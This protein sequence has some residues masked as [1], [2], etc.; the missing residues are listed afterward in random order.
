MKQDGK[1]FSPIS[2]GNPESLLQQAADGELV[3]FAA[4]RQSFCML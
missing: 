1:E 2:E 3:L 4:A